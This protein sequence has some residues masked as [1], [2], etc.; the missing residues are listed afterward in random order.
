M[1]THA[2][3]RNGWFDEIRFIVWG[4]LQ[5]LLVADKDI[6]ARGPLTEFLKNGYQ[7]LTF[8]QNIFNLNPAVARGCR[9]QLL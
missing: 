4:Q 3:K 8:W 6:T 5:R 9:V 7:M 1:Y 2:G